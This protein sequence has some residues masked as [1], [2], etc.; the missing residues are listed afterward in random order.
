[1][2]TPI[3]DSYDKIFG[4]KKRIMTVFAHP[5]D[6]ELYCGGTI[7]R[8]IAD[9]KIVRSVKMTS[10]EMGSRQQVIT[11]EELLKLREKED[12][13]AMNS[14]GILPEN[15]IYLRAGDGKIENSIDLIGQVALQIRLFQPDLIITHNSEDLIIRWDEDENWFNHRDHRHT[16]QTV[17]DASY[18]GA[19]DV[20]FY[21]EHFKNPSA[22]SWSC[23]QFLFVDSYGHQDSVFIDMTDFV[24]KRITAHA[25]H[26][27][28]YSKKGAQE[29]ADFFTQKW[30]PTGKRNFETFRYVVAD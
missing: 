10:G 25:M 26:S 11:S 24:E 23:T 7:S 2:T 29:S 16:G 1:M 13:A 18:P 5:D 20:L 4:D 9:G 8:L 6:L 30:D 19:R 21:P 3:I 27:S 22:K 14:L 15:N 28:Q 12:T 17:I